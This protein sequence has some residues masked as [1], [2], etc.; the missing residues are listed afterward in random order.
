MNADE[1]VIHGV[2]AI[3][4]AWFSIFFENAFVNRVKRSG[5]SRCY[6]DNRF[7]EL[8][9]VPRAFGVTCYSYFPATP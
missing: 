8:V 3:A 7:G 6:I 4:A 5:F 9:G 1:I 2:K